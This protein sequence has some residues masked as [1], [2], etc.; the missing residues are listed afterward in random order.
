MVP[1]AEYQNQYLRLYR[2]DS[3]VQLH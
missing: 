2:F 3:H 1:V